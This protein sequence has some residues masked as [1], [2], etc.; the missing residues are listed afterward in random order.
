[1]PKTVA[2]TGAGSGI[3]L[4]AALHYAGQGW[5]VGLIGRGADALA[6]ASRRV[7][8]AGG[9]GHPVVADVADG[10]ALDRAAA[11]IEA[12]LGPIDVWINNAAIGFYGTFVEIP[13]ADF[14]AVVETNL[15]GTI[16]GTRTA[17][18]LMRPRGR[19][20]IVQVLSAISYRGV[21]L[22]SPYSTSK[23][24]L[25]GFTEALRAELVHERSGVHVTMLHPP[26]VNTPFYSHAGSVMDKTP[27]PPPPV[28]QP[29]MLGEAL[30][31]AGTV[32]R[33]EWVVGGQAAAVVLGNKV[34]PGLVDVL[35]GLFAVRL[36][37]TT[38]KDVAAARDP[39]VS[40]PG[41]RLP[42]THG[43]FDSESLGSSLQ[44]WLSKRGR[45][46][47]LGLGLAALGAVQA[48]RRRRA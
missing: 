41:A 26:A 2:I 9:R 23:F 21:P 35:T 22:Q 20:T 47:Q 15:F 29:E 7:A 27:R 33:R 30:Y 6:E 17:L 14:R 19:G 34:A 1:M 43:P 42:G 46:V 5:R 38:R 8:E 4:A 13:Q 25:R 37:Q 18:A 31:L 32:K 16:N 28:Y 10:A 3:G 12:A 45:V 48:I 44:W 40:G 36:Q 24:A 11:A 39:N